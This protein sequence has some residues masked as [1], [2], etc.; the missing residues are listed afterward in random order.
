MNNEKNIEVEIRGR[1]ADEKFNE[2]VDYFRKNAKFK[3]EKNRVLI[4][5][6]TFLPNE[7]VED[8]Q[9]DIR[10]RITNGVPEIVV[11]FGVWGAQEVRKE[12]SVLAQPGDFEK[13]VQIFA[14]MGF[15]KGMM[16]V[17]KSQIFDYK[18]IEFALV[19]VPGHSHYFEAE[20][21]AHSGEDADRVRATIRGVCQELGMTIF[22]TDR[23]FFDYINILNKEANKVFDFAQFKDGYFDSLI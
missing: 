1:I 22:Q 9:R 19:E 13:L 11:K 3:Q 10:L 7:G 17:R 4:D 15:V 6:S 16:C 23:E 12:L 18:D 21:M 20:I 2:L 5:Y 8:R 14:A